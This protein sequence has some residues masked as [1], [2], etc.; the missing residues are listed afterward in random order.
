MSSERVR[1]SASHK[2]STRSI[3]AGGS[4]TVI[5]SVVR[6][7]AGPSSTEQVR[8]RQRLDPLRLRLGSFAGRRAWSRPRL[9]TYPRNM[10]EMVICTREDLTTRYG[11]SRCVWVGFARGPMLGVV[12]G[13]ARE[14]FFLYSASSFRIRLRIDSSSCRQR[15]SEPRSAVASSAPCGAQASV[16]E[17]DADLPQRPAAL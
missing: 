4:D 2:R 14:W 13:G 5:V 7:I 3:I 6:A 15:R 16:V 10:E 12:L 8:Q 9:I 17:C 11:L 1:C